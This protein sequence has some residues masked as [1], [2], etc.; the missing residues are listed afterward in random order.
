MARPDVGP[1]R[2]FQARCA[3]G[4]RDRDPAA[5]AFCHALYL[6]SAKNAGAALA[7]FDAGLAG[8]AETQGVD[9]VALG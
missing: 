3:V 2:P 7:T 6:V 5:V 4:R 1:R 8:A 9:V